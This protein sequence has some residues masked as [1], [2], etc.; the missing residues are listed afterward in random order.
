MYLG[1]T[2]SSLV[3]FVS[4]YSPVSV[5]ISNTY[6]ILITLILLYALETKSLERQARREE[7]HYQFQIQQIILHQRNQNKPHQWTNQD[8]KRMKK[9]KRITG[10]L[11]FFTTIAYLSHLLN[12]AV[13]DRLGNV[14]NV[15]GSKNV[16]FL[17][18][19]YFMMD[20][21]SIELSGV[22]TGQ[23]VVLDWVCPTLTYF[24]NAFHIVEFL[25]QPHVLAHVYIYSPC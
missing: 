16:V 8:Q 6:N 4:F 25:P 2:S 21:P 17:S 14:V 7:Q 24:N 20:D 9:R 13:D 12:V 10:W 22:Q 11:V 19:P 18:G 5:G 3:S 15:D 1:N 23:T